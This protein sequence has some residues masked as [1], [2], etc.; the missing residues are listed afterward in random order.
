MVSNEAG[1][2]GIRGK[3]MKIFVIYD[4]SL[5]HFEALIDMSAK[6]ESDLRIDSNDT[7][8]Q[9]FLQLLYL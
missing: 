1:T 8:K 7:V 5:G 4:Q 3:S 6:V 2:A 9:E